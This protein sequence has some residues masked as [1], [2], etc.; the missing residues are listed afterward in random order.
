MT[1]FFKILIPF[2]LCFSSPLMANLFEVESA[3]TV[4][5]KQQYVVD[6]KVVYRFTEEALE[7]LQNGV[8]LTL[9]L[10]IHLQK[11][12]AWFWK[13]NLVEHTFRYQL[14]FHPLTETYQV[15]DLAASDKH[16]FETLDAAKDLLG[17]IAHLPLIQAVK[18]HKGEKYKVAIKA[19]L[20]IEALP[21]PLRPL[22]YISS[23]WDMESD[24]FYWTLT[25]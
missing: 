23:A 9:N 25:P 4:L 6:T 14:R 7:A 24:W 16:S 1:L 12:D 13:P 15:W 21:L 22:A 3:S 10:I 11:A 17:D 18:L 2:W 20:D 5:V 19:S 8:P